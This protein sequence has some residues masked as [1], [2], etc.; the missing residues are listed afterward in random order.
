[1]PNDLPM[2]DFEFKEARRPSYEPHALPIEKVRAGSDLK[3]GQEWTL[4]ATHELL[5]INPATG[6]GSWP[7]VTP[8]T[9]QVRREALLG[10]AAVLR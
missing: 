9:K 2:R 10:I 8:S 6:G 4:T 3:A 5:D 7:P 1:M